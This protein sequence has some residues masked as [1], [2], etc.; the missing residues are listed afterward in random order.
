MGAM[1]DD[2][3]MTVF[4]AVVGEL[5]L[6][7]DIRSWMDLSRLLKARGHNFQASRLSGWAYGQHDA[8]W[9]FVRAL[10][11]VLRLEAEER[12]RLAMTFAYGQGER[13][14]KSYLSAKKEPTIKE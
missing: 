5:M 3:R 4:G 8:D 11:D 1:A 9:R 14:N 6:G 12:T 13:I 10:A 2:P 7:R